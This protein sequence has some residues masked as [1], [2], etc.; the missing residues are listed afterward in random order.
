M[1]TGATQSLTSIIQHVLDTH[2]VY[3]RSELPF[4]EERLAMMCANHGKDRPEL[5]TL[6]QLLQN[7]RDDL[8]DHLAK[9]EQ[10]LF[11]YAAALE[12]ALE[13]GAPMPQACFPTVQAPIRVMHMEHDAA[14]DLL[15]QLRAAS[16]NYADPG[17]FCENGAEFY[18]RLAA[19][20]ADLQ[21][22][23]R[24]ENEVLFPRAV[25]LEESVR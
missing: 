18:R 24:I 21:E 8:M 7:L 9:E 15:Q 4:L 2:H 23:I 1:P 25:Q 10:I 12:A 11:P 13:K 19:L 22:H 17:C 16:A 5:F 3:L 6:Q 20:D 14:R